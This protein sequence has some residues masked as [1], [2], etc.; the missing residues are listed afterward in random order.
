MS[1]LRNYI[2]LI[3]S[4]IAISCSQTQNIVQQEDCQNLDWQRLGWQ[5]GAKGLSIR[6]LDYHIKRCPP[7]IESAARSLYIKGHELGVP[8]YC[9]YRIGFIKGDERDPIPSLCED[10]RFSEFHKG[11][12]AGIKASSK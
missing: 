10:L 2:L 11:Y 1:H 3:L 8:E 6:M 5:E 7:E 4:F 12:R 9:T